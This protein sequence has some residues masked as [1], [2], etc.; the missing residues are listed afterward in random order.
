[1]AETRGGVVRSS[2][3]SKLQVIVTVHF[4]QQYGT[5]QTR[6]STDHAVNP[7]PSPL[8]PPTP[9][10]GPSRIMNTPRLTAYI[11]FSLF[12]HQRTGPDKESNTQGSPVRG[13]FFIS[14][15]SRAGG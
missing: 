8:S 5:A 14:V 15:L 7:P 6:G 1:M 13:R 9:T 12:L 10:E 3:H 2:S 11:S 4:T